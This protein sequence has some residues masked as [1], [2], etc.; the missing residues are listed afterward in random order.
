M[1]CCI[2]YDENLETS[3][4]CNNDEC[5]HHIC[6]DCS[7][8]YLNF[9]KDQY[10]TLPVCPNT[11]CRYEYLYKN[12]PKIY[13]DTY[14]ELLVTYISRDELLSTYVDI[15]EIINKLINEK[16]KFIKKTFPKCID[17]IINVAL[18]KN[19]E[20]LTLKMRMRMINIPNVLICFVN[21]VFYL[22][23]NIHLIVKFVK[24]NFVNY[25]IKI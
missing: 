25:V 24:L 6:L 7:E 4:T 17:I 23:L 11:E 20:I 16:R 1:Q 14:T 22:N 8:S 18:K 2:C 9:C 12:I 19:Y 21:Q 3:L 13:I 5:N 15:K 10:K